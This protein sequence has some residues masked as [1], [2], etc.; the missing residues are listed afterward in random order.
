MKSDRQHGDIDESGYYVFDKN[1]SKDLRFTFYLEIPGQIVL[2]MK[3]PPQINYRKKDLKLNN[4]NSK[5]RKAHQASKK[6]MMKKIPAK[7]TKK[8]ILI[9]KLSDLL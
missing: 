2:L 4:S 7:V 3:L 9:K 5:M 8:M 6:M 1:K